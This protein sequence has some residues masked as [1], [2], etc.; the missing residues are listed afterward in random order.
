MIRY[1]RGGWFQVVIYS[2]ILIWYLSVHIPYLLKYW[3]RKNWPSADAMI[4]KGTM[5]SVAQGRSAVPAC[6]IGYAFKVEGLRYGAYFV[7]VGKADFLEK[8]NKELT[9]ASLQVRYDPSNPTSSLLIDYK[10][11]RFAGLRAS[12]DPDW[13]NQAPAFDLQDAIRG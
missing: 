7:L 8:V 4:Q 11:F 10:D 3:R 1:D 2:A 6:F 12:Q 5:G 13:L 9:G